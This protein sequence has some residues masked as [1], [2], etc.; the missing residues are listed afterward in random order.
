M[1]REGMIFI[2]EDLLINLMIQAETVPVEKVEND[3]R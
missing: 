1:T 3:N 2:E